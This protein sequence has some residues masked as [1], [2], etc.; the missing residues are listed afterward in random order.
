MNSITRLVLSLALIVG[1]ASLAAAQFTISIPK[2]P[3]IPKIRKDRPTTSDASTDKNTATASN[4][5]MTDE[6]YEAFRTLVFD[7]DHP[8]TML[9]LAYMECYDKKHNLKHNQYRYGEV[10]QFATNKEKVDTLTAEQTQLAQLE[11]DLRAIGVSDNGADDLGNPA[12][13]LDITGN[14]Q[15]YLQ[16]VLNDVPKPGECGKLD[17]ARQARVDSYKEE[18]QELLGEVKSFNGD[19]GWYSSRYREDWLLAA[20]SPSTRKE[21]AP[22]YGDAFPCITG[23]L[24]EI[25]AA[26]KLTLPK[27]TLY[28][29]NVR[30]PAGERII[31]SAIPDLNKGKVFKTGFLESV[32]LIEKNSIGI[33]ERRFKHGA[34]W[35]KFPGWDHGYCQI[36]W[37]NLLQDYT[38]G[39][40]WG[41]SYPNFIRSEPAGCPTGAKAK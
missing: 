24:D 1:S 2:I 36:L 18:L 27:Y 35:V 9:V 23:L 28:S 22:N 31:K 17:D 32:W 39:G 38:G 26:A 15:Q 34:I 20:I 3:K 14:R 29:Y 16:C 25:K 21:I 7:R 19:R 30:N 4:G 11:R 40:T 6:Q 5:Q 12:I 33:P 41:A 10:R 8:K 37:V 13:W